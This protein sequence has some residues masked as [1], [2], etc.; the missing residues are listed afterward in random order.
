MI[1]ESELPVKL[2]KLNPDPSTP[3]VLHGPSAVV[4]NGNSS[5]ISV[6]RENRTP[7]SVTGTYCSSQ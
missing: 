5:A 2:G 6:P 1:A 4:V 7:S 3:N